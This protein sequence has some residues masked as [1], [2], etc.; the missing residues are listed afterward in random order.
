[1]TLTH[2][3]IEHP[4]LQKFLGIDTRFNPRYER[5]AIQSSSLADVLGEEIKEA[6]YEETLKTE[7]GKAFDIELE[8]SPK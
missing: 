8:S 2:E 7:E 6:E 4:S 5:E 3:A 1:M